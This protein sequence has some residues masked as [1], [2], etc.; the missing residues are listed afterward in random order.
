MEDYS[1]G[2]VAE[3][4]FWENWFK[5]KGGEFEWDYLA[6]TNPQA[7][8][9]SKFLK[10]FE[11]FISQKSYLRIMDVG[12]GPISAINNLRF[13]FPRTNIKLF[14]IDPLARKYNDFISSA[15]L[16]DRIVLPIEGVG[17]LLSDLGMSDFDIIYSRNALDHSNDPIM[18]IFQIINLLKV[19]G[20]AFLDHA[21]NEAEYEK[22][23]GTHHWNFTIEDSHFIIWSKSSK[24]NVTKM[25]SKF[26]A[27]SAERIFEGGRNKIIVIVEK[28][29]P[30]RVKFPRSLKAYRELLRGLEF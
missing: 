19:G 17:E 30:S 26:S 22:Y 13:Q 6:R 12:S 9:D 25:L 15:G 3:S 14:P 7:P 16:S 29:K 20:F 2:F 4:N 18:V 1:S 24:F 27:I 21:E 8:I 5:S 23:D 11:A 28:Q 10:H